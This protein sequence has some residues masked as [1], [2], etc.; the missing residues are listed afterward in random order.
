M[1]SWWIL[2]ITDHK[3]TVMH[4]TKLV[5]K[6]HFTAGHPL[7]RV[8]PLVEEDSTNKEV[9]HLVEELHTSGYWP[10][11][12]QNIGYKMK[13]S[14][15]TEIH[16]HS[17][18]IVLISG[19]CKECREHI[20]LFL[21]QLHELS[22]VKSTW[23]SWN[24]A[25]KFIVSVMSNCSHMKNTNFFRAI[26]RELCLKVFINAVFLFL[27]LN[28]HGG[29]DIQQN[30]N[31]S[32]QG[33]YLE[34]HTWYPYENL[35]RCHPNE[36]TVPVKVFTV[37]N[38]SDIRR[39][40]TF[41]GYIDKNFHRCPGKMYIRELP[42][43]VYPLK[44]IRYNDSYC[45]NVY[46][47]GCETELLKLIGKTL[48]VSLDMA[49]VGEVVDNS[50]AEDSK[51]VERLKGQP[52]KFVRW[53]AGV[54]PQFDCSIE[55][56]CSDLSVHAVWYTLCAVKYQRL[57]CFFNIFSVD[58][59][60][61]FA[62]SL[63][64]A[65]ITVNCIS[66]YGQKS[67]MHE[68]K[69]YNNIFSVTANI[70]AISLSVSV[71]TQPRS[72]PLRLFFFCWVWYSVAVSTVFQAYL[73]M[74]LIEPGYEEP[75]KNINQMLKSKINFGFDAVY[76]MLFTNTEDPVESAILEDSV[77]YPEAVCFN[78]VALHHNISAILK[79]LVLGTLRARGN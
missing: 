22:V 37:G 48:N 41:R 63:V 20:S 15:Y 33:T 58:M 74:F 72:A 73:T 18:Y 67:H 44:C 42:F 47:D 46:K 38:L 11:L 19:P 61:Y 56:T 36:G 60:I 55:Y 70:I 76:T 69:S 28:E 68:S 43:L 59:W 21:R 40:D 53:Y 75:I 14:T 24:P 7:V 2:Q 27:K 45:Q 6:E 39:I 32:A 79:E 26:L 34:L 49:D 29:N 35:D 23:H 78:W 17:S 3:D 8:L 71:N 66:N 57:N 30:T 54:F 64:L 51:E 62:L 12:V 10:I 77:V 9:G 31:E 5:S 50:I 4:Y 16:Q 1:Y 13:G 52:F 25:P 65:A